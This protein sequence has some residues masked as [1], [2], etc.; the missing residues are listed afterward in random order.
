MQVTVEIFAHV[1]VV[2]CPSCLTSVL[3]MGDSNAGFSACVW[4]QQCE[5]LIC[6]FV[7]LFVFWG[8]KFRIRCSCFFPPKNVR[9]TFLLYCFVLIEAACVLWERPSQF[10]DEAMHPAYAYI[11]CTDTFIDIC[12]CD[13]SMNYI[14]KKYQE[15]SCVCFLHCFVLL[16]LPF[17]PFPVEGSYPNP[18]TLKKSIS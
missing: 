7:C 11:R 9:D 15:K 2:F 5:K 10:N 14:F 16:T 13:H 1:I 4:S 6:L 17:E 8:K 18:P 3:L 12:L